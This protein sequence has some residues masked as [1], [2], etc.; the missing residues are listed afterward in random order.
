MKI[1]CTQENLHQGLSITSHLV[2]KNVNLPILQN[3]LVKADGGIVKFTATNLEIAINCSVRGKID[4]QG[5]FT[6]PSKLFFDYVSLL[7]NEVIHLETNGDQVLVECGGH[8]TKIHGMNAS[9]FPLVPKVEGDTS[10][11]IPID[12]LKAALSQVLFSV[13]TNE[14]R[15][16]LTGVLMHFYPFQQEMRLTLASTDSYRLSEKTIPVTSGPMQDFLVVIPAKTLS[17]V[18]RVLSVFRDEVDLPS[19]ITMQVKQNQVVFM[20]GP[21]ELVSRTIEENYPDYE[22]IIPKQ[23]Q[24]QALVDREDFIKAVKTAALFS[25][26]GLFDVTLSFSPTEKRVSVQALDATR[27]E[28]TTTCDADITGVQNT[29]TVNFRYLLDGL[30]SMSGDQVMFQLIDAS[31]PCLLTTKDKPKEHRYIV[32]PIKQ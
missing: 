16:E 12:D 23:F 18:N 17:E 14:S 11:Q 22:Q 5:E 7:P 27:G 30:Q 21:V 15:P 31:N 4:E 20:Y 24:T 13:A 26:N 2:T 8:K 25:K 10:F 19:Y 3:V 29:V 28:N 6:I 1:S 32:M 9:D